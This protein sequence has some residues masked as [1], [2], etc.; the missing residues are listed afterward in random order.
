MC[1]SCEAVMIN[2]VHCHE[3]SCPESWKG[4]KLECTWCGCEFLPEIQGQLFCSHQCG[5]GYNS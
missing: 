5:D 4:K 2:H 1:D 3:H